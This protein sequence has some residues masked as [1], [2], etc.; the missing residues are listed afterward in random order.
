MIVSPITHFG[1]GELDDL[2]TEEPWKVPYVPNTL[3]KDNQLREIG[4]AS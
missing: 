2:G 4:G 1:L 3:T